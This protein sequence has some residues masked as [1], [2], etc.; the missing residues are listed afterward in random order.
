MRISRRVLISGGRAQYFHVVSRVVDR[1]YIFTEREKEV[2]LR[3]MRKQEAFSGVEVVSY[4]IMSNHFHILL[5]VPLRPETMSKEE[6]WRRMAHIY[7]EEKLEEMRWMIEDHARAC[8]GE[9]ENSYEREFLE[10]IQERMYDLS[11]FVRELK[12]KFSKWYNRENNRKGTLWEERFKSVLVEGNENCLIR[13][14]SYIE[15]NAVRAGIVSNP[16]KYTWCSFGAACLGDRQARTGL[17]GAIN[18]HDK[19]PWDWARV[20]RKFEEIFEISLKIN[21][22]S[23]E[24]THQIER[25]KRQRSR[26]TQKTS[27]GE[28]LRLVERIRHFTEGVVIG[29]RE[30]ING[31]YFRNKDKISPNRER[32]KISYNM[33]RSGDTEIYSYRNV[34]KPTS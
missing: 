22:E 28:R 5:H 12:L 19:T 30:F 6:T 17:E 16:E 23:T 31:F 3:M 11:H 10:G 7:S 32:K 15:M 4:S 34:R 2:F 27:G 21:D 25:S 13:C 26:T 14:A 29:S 18:I 8:E 33:E 20:K 1:R 9:R 24:G